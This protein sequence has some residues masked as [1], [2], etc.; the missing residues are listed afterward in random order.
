ML[1]LILFVSFISPRA[2]QMQGLKRRL[3]RSWKDSFRM[4]CDTRKNWAKGKAKLWRVLKAQGGITCLN[5]DEVE[6]QCL[7]LQQFTLWR[8]SICYGW[9]ERDLVLMGCKDGARGNIELWSLQRSQ[10]LDTILHHRYLSLQHWYFS[11]ALVK[12]EHVMFVITPIV[13]FTIGI[14]WMGWFYEKELKECTR[15]LTI[16]L[17]RVRIHNRVVLFPAGTETITTN[18]GNIFIGVDHVSWIWRVGLTDKWKTQCSGSP[19]FWSAGYSVYTVREWLCAL[20]C[21]LLV[22]SFYE[23]RKDRF[24][25]CFKLYQLSINSP[26]H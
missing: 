24:V 10:R 13:P 21:K 26:L 22:G 17:S 7:L 25:F 6:T 15:V 9:Q 8:W 19:H 20:A 3:N 1:C 18:C 16:K 23:G 4:L 12:E 11:N 2:S 5:L 14:G